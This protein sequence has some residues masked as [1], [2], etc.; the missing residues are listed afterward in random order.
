MCSLWYSPAMLFNLVNKVC[1]TS[2]PHTVL[3]HWAGCTPGL[4]IKMFCTC[5]A[6]IIDRCIQTHKGCKILTTLLCNASRSF[7]SSA[8]SVLKLSCAGAYFPSL[9]SARPLPA[10]PRTRHCL[11]PVLLQGTQV[12]H[13]P[14]YA[15]KTKL[16]EAPMLQNLTGI[17]K[18]NPQCENKTFKRAWIFFQRF[19]TLPP[20]M[21]VTVFWFTLKN[22]TLSTTTS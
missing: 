11:S 10:L 15:T 1:S 19:Y 9:W 14:L 16:Q 8:V 3:Q 2:K 12:R 7:H 13:L 22:R 6:K 18:E 21:S 20:T 5:T 4:E 17:K